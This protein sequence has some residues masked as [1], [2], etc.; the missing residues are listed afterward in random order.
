MRHFILTI[1]LIVVSAAPSIC[2]EY[3]IFK[4]HGEV[5]LKRKGESEWHGVEK[6]NPLAPQ[7]ILRIDDNSSVMIIDI[8]SGQI[9]RSTFS[10]EKSVYDIVSSAKVASASMTALACQELYGEIKTNSMQDNDLRVGAV[11]RGDNDMSDLDSLAK[12]LFK[13][14]NVELHIVDDEDGVVHLSLKNLANKPLYVNVVRISPI[15][16]RHICF[17]FKPGSDCEGLLLP[18]GASIDLPQY[19]FDSNGSTF[20]PFTTTFKYDTRALQRRL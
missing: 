20:H 5:A 7:D 19:Q 17:E 14:K 9:F 4:V 6:R 16:A 2:A 1:A 10:G 18:E 3:A 11:F 15:G 8:E 12:H 13:D